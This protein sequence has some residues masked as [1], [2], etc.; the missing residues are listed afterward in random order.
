[1]VHLVFLG[2]LFCTIPELNKKYPFRFFTFAI[3]FMFMALRYDYGND[4][5]SYLDIHTSIN[6]GLYAW[7]ADDT[8]FRIL[9]IAV[10]NFFVMIAL[11]SLFYLIVVWYLLKINLKVSQYWFAVLI[12]LINPYL[13]LIHLS[14]LRQTLAL[15]IFVFAVNFAVKRKLIPYAICIL[16]ATGMHSSA[17]ILFPMYF[18]LTEKPF[19]KKYLLIT[20]VGLGLL[21]LTPLFDIIANNVL[22]YLPNQYK[23]YYNQGLQNSIRATIISSFYLLLIAFNLGKLRGKEIIYGKLSLIATILSVLAI[24]VS[25]ITRI[26]MY[27]ELFLIITIPHIF[28]RIERKIYKQILFTVL[29]GIYLLR[30]YSFFTNPLWESFREY[31]TILGR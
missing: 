6:A 17:I 7:G 30:Y 15:C 10:P 11:I 24:K 16:L 26:G 21:L 1:M 25:M 31:Q 27:F 22:D 5:M 12:L 4:Y 14:A 13:F 3:L 2:A 23:F 8:L 18:F 29:I 20:I 28:N 9:N 19:N